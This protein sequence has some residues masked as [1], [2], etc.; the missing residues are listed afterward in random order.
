MFYLHKAVKCYTSVL[1]ALRQGESNRFL[2]SILTR[3]I[4]CDVE[5]PQKK[6][7]KKNSEDGQINLFDQNIQHYY[8]KSPVQLYEARPRRY[9][10][11]F[12]KNLSFS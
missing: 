12:L 1:S 11:F 6:L 3:N 9:F 4:V 8:T 7:P 2:K 5:V 10:S